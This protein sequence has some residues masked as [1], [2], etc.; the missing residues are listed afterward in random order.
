MLDCHQAKFTRHFSIL[1]S[2]Q[3][4]QQVLCLHNDKQKLIVISADQYVLFDMQ[5]NDTVKHFKSNKKQQPPLMIALS[6]DDKFA[7]EINSEFPTSIL[8]RNL[9]TNSLVAKFE[10]HSQNVTSVN[11]ADSQDG[12]YSFVSCAGSECLLWQTPAEAIS[13]NGTSLQE[14]LQPAKILDIESSLSIKKISALEAMK[15]AF[16][17]LA[18]SDRKSFVFLAKLN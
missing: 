2:H 9:V 6:F 17:V 16:L 14:I 12:S 3:P 18:C 1:K 13:S 8:M 11:F 7:L 10:G 15:G 5:K 4:I